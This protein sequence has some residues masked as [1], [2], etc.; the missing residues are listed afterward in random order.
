MAYILYT[1]DTERGPAAYTQHCFASLGELRT[2][3]EKETTP[4]LAKLLNEPCPESAEKN[5]DTSVLLTADCF[6]SDIR[7]LK[8]AI[9]AKNWKQAAEEY[10][11]FVCSNLIEYTGASLSLVPVSA[12]HAP[13][14]DEHQSG[15]SIEE[16]NVL[17]SLIHRIPI[18][19][20]LSVFS[21]TFRESTFAD[22]L[23]SFISEELAKVSYNMAEKTGQT[24]MGTFLVCKHEITKELLQ[25]YSLVARCHAYKSWKDIA[26]AYEDE[27]DEEK[28]A[29]RVCREY[30]QGGM[31]D[32]LREYLLSLVIMCYYAPTYNTR[33]T[34]GSAELFNQIQMLD[35]GI[36]PKKLMFALMKDLTHS[37][38]K[39]ALA[40]LDINCV[41]RSEGMKYIGIRNAGF[42]KQEE[43][44]GPHPLNDSDLAYFDVFFEPPLNTGAKEEAEKPTGTGI[45]KR[46]DSQLEFINKL[47]TT[48]NPIVKGSPTK[49]TKEEEETIA[50]FIEVI[51][52]T[53]IILPPDMPVEQ[54]RLYNIAKERI[55]TSSSKSVPLDELPSAE[56]G[57]HLYEAY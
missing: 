20:M 6:S 14:V 38:V 15:I 50:R 54:Q 25:I 11:H 8:R 40:A 7:V 1:P 36:V 46:D 12:R 55:R 2:W 23:S 47:L 33:D 56:E 19:D 26:L 17:V 9:D 43:M 48:Y 18:K 3:V 5:I 45:V 24:G 53:C 16:Y 41:R 57:V 42:N 32:K 52:E 35:F 37:H 51:Q 28:L 13:I 49:Y 29:I 39:H 22:Q 21:P 34:I 4:P 31:T 27:K 30:I 10:L 44:Q